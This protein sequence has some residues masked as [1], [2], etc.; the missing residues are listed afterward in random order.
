MRNISR[1]SRVVKGAGLKIPCVSFV[2]SNPTSCI[3]ISIQ[4]ILFKKSNSALNLK[5]KEIAFWAQL[6][7][8]VERQ[9]FKLVV[10]G[11]SPTL[12][13]FL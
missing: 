2:G 5:A 3:F 9:P 13:V 10:V 11:S 6:A 4:H 1:D 8:S 7:Q 12:G